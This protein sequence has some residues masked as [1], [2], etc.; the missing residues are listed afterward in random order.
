MAINNVVISGNLTRDAELRE[1]KNDGA[2]LNF[3]VAVND[4]FYDRDAEEYAE[5]ANYFDC[6]MFGARAKA[7]ADYLKKGTKVAVSGKLHYSSWETDEGKRSKVEITALEIEFLS[8]RSEDEKP[9]RK[10]YNRR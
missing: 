2:V 1:L 6:V 9:K 7:L 3:S 5:Y 10:S 8:A 4:R